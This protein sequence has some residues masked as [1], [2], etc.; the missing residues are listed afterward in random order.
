MPKSYITMKIRMSKFNQDDGEIIETDV[1]F[2]G[3]TAHLC[4]EHDID[5]FYD[6]SVNGILE[7]FAEFNENGCN[8]VCKRVSDMQVNTVGI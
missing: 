1:E 6:E 8:W 2:N 4:G 3:G 5:E 7:D